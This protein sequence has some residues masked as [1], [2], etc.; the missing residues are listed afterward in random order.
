MGSELNIKLYGPSGDGCHV[1]VNGEW[2]AYGNTPEN[3]WKAALRRAIE[4]NPA[5]PRVD[6][7][8]ILA[9]IAA[10]EAFAELCEGIGEEPKWLKDAR[11]LL[12]AALP[13]GSE[14]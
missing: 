13:E 6:A 7:M 3:A 11:E 8:N 1:E 2:Y 14:K 12:A 10:D 5:S 9:R 4:S